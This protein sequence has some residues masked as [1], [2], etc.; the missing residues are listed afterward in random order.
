MVAIVPYISLL[1]ISSHTPMDGGS[2]ARSRQPHWESFEVKCL[3]QG[4]DGLGWRGVLIEGFLIKKLLIQ[5]IHRKAHRHCCIIILYY[6]CR[7]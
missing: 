7:F 6:T 5:Q 2:N 4:H 3:A 1:F